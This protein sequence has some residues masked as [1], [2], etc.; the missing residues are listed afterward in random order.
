MRGCAAFWGYAASCVRVYHSRWRH[1]RVGPQPLDEFPA[2]GERGDRRVIRFAWRQLVRRK[3]PAATLTVGFLVA[4]VSFT[5]LTSAA[6][7]GALEVKGT[8]AKNW[9]NAYDI[10]VRPGRTYSPLER[11]DGLVADDYLSGIFGGITLN[12]WRQVLS[13]PGVAIA[14]P[15]ANLGYVVTSATVTIHLGSSLNADPRQ[16]YRI[17]LAWAANG[18]S[19][20][21]GS[22]PYVYVSRLA[23]DA[24]PDRSFGAPTT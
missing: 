23:H 6:T 21:P 4:A 13:I 12:Q 11:A 15:V 5:L 19:V 14:A 16:I 9:R 18:G 22:T 8:I 7:T 1:D 10:L 3:G 2:G 20:Y 17:R 24:C